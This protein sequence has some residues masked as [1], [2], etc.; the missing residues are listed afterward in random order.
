M[1]SARDERV[2]AILEETLA[3]RREELTPLALLVEDLGMD[4]LDRVEISMALEEAFDVERIDEGEA[5][6]WRTVADV[7]AT[8][9]KMARKN[10]R[11]QEDEDGDIGDTGDLE[12]AIVER[13]F[14]V[15]LLGTVS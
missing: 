10:Y 11:P 12:I 4:S 5:E 14:A 9:K 13:K 3:V 15:P 1:K 6:R 2:L 7:Q 8:A